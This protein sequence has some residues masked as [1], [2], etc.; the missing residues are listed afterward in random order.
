MLF[1]IVSVTRPHEALTPLAVT[2]ICYII[3]SIIQVIKWLSSKSYWLIPLIMGLFAIFKALDAALGSFQQV[4]D[5]ISSISR[6]SP[7]FATLE[8]PVSKHCFP[9]TREES[10]AF[11]CWVWPSVEK[12][13]RPPG[14]PARVR[15]S[16][17]SVLPSS[18]GD[19]LTPRCALRPSG[20]VTLPHDLGRGLESSV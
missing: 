15:L 11:L 19:H 2:V 3:I 16:L 18:Q 17:P 9:L 7:G 14:L 8:D 10:A 4:M 6:Q 13:F 12:A 20:D 5:S 1:L